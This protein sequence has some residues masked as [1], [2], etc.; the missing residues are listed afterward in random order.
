MVCQLKNCHVPAI[1]HMPARTNITQR[2][3]LNE[4]KAGVVSRILFTLFKRRSFICAINPELYHMCGIRRA[5]SSSLFDLAP[6]GV[7]HAA[8]IT[9]GP[10]VSYTAVSPLPHDVSIEWRSVFCGTFHPD[11]FTGRLPASRRD[12][13]PYGVRT[14]L[15]AL[16]RSDRTPLHRHYR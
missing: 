1:V 5:A 15:P 14:F 16:K 9:V 7:C 6:G 4:K 12:T 11:R 10:V 13:L 2:R 8:S 3:A